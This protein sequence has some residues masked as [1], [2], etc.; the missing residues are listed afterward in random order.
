MRRQYI[1]KEQLHSIVTNIVNEEIQQA[2]LNEGM[3]NK[4]IYGLWGGGNTNNV[5]GSNN[6]FI[7]LVNSF[8]NILYQLT[9]MGAFNDANVYKAL[10]VV[11]NALNTQRN[12][13]FNGQQQ[14][15]GQ[16]PQ[17]NQQVPSP[18]P[19]PTNMP[20]Q[21]GQNSNHSG[22][23]SQTNASASS[24]PSN[25]PSYNYTDGNNQSGYTYNYS[26]LQGGQAAKRKR[27]K[28]RKPNRFSEYYN[29]NKN[30]SIIRKRISNLV[31]EAMQSTT[32]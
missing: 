31:H 7:K 16:S 14:S 11:A 2:A 4:L 9:E 12:Q 19:L 22:N 15:Q 20:R 6:P 27:K 32:K 21:N 29:M 28:K 1:N 8:E 5:Y 17:Q 25:W 3:L 24:L 26:P 23:Q 13:V 18:S 10:Q 30:E